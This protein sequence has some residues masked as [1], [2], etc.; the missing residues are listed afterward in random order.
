M[1]CPSYPAN[2]INSQMTRSFPLTLMA[3][4]AAASF[5]VEGAP[6]EDIPE[7]TRQWMSGDDF[8][9]KGTI[10]GKFYQARL[11]GAN[12]EGVDFE[13]ATF[14]QCD[15]AG[16]NLRGA[17][18]RDGTRLHLVTINGANL[19]GTDFEQVEIESVNFRGANLRNAK[20][21][22]KLKEANFQRADLRGADFS[23]VETPLIEVDFTDA[24]YDD[25]TKFP[26]GIDPVKVGAK[27]K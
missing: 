27:R 20:G 14:V 13:H 1:L 18:F 22:T 11:N 8:T 21:F 25:R 15:L 2:L 10:R 23:G 6:A 24:I 26:K 5:F 16:A 9:S 17:T 19:E 12:F 4:V 7:F 3:S